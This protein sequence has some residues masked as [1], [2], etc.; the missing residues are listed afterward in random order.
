MRDPQSIPS[1]RRWPN[2]PNESIRQFGHHLMESRPDV[3]RSIRR[4]LRKHK[5][6]QQIG[7]AGRRLTVANRGEAF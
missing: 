2:E 5:R 1:S 4:Q 6:H 3:S 7:D